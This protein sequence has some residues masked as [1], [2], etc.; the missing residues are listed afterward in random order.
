MYNLR[1]SRQISDN[2]CISIG[3]PFAVDQPVNI[4]HLERNMDVA[5]EVVNVRS[6]E[7]GLRPRYG[8][9]QRKPLGTLEA[10]EEELNDLLDAMEGSDGEKKRMNA[11]KIGTSLGQGTYIDDLIHVGSRFR[12]FCYRTNKFTDYSHQA[13]TPSSQLI[14]LT[15]PIFTIH[16]HTIFTSH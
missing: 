10:L 6:G 5:F 2:I 9:V 12:S 7:H 3:W 4:A 16:I 13:P 11:K 15:N 14:V 8:E 1:F